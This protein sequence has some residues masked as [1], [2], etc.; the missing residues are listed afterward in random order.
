MEMF[1]HIHL[2]RLQAIERC[3]WLAILDDGLLQDAL[4]VQSRA[5]SP[6]RV[7]VCEPQQE[8]YLFEF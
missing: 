4:N 5:N 8:R 6:G 1:A 3:I 7:V 2:G